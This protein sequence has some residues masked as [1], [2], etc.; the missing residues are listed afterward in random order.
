LEPLFSLF[1]LFSFSFHSCFLTSLF[2]F[3]LIRIRTRMPVLNNRGF[4][5][6]KPNRVCKLIAVVCLHE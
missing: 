2:S 5:S 6:Q 3:T 1:L 4:C